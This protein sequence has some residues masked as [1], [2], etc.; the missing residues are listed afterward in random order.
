MPGDNALSYA[1]DFRFA[2]NLTSSRKGTCGYLLA[3][4]GL[5]GLSLK[6]DIE[7]WNPFDGAGQTVVSGATIKCIGLIETLSY[8]G[9]ETDPIRIKCYVSKGT[10]TELRSKLGRPLTNTKLKLAFYVID[11]DEDSK[12]WYEAVF[13]KQPTQA[14]ASIDSQ[15]GTLQMFVDSAPTK[16]SPTLDLNLFAFEFQVVPQDGKSVNLEF[17]TGPAQRLVKCWGEAT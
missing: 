8:E 12:K 6:Q 5:G 14:D 4:A 16:A 7:V 9:G 13:A 11:F 2:L 3:F 17:A 10:Q 15:G 1:C